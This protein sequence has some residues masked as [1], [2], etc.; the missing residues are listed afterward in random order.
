MKLDMVSGFMQLKHITT[1]V[2]HENSSRYSWP[3]SKLI[4]ESKYFQFLGSLQLH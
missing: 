3:A 4:H 2:L 1:V